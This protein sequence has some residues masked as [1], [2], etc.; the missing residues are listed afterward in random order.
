MP[1]ILQRLALFVMTLTAVAS[2]A[3]AGAVS[4][5]EWTR[6]SSAISNQRWSDAITL[7]L[8]YLHRIPENDDDL[9]SEWWVRKTNRR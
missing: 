3:Q 7:S 2:S 8:D 4:Q 5:G 9:R 6:L 1:G